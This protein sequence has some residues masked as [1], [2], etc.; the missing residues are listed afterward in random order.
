MQLAP[1]I[2][3]IIHFILFR[4]SSSSS[5]ELLGN[6]PVGR[7]CS[8]QVGSRDYT[9]FVQGVSVR[10]GSLQAVQ[11]RCASEFH[12]FVEQLLTRWNN[13]DLIRAFRS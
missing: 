7:D 6:L 2:Q 13:P 10:K 9:C 12:L 1:A 4:V 5:K 11:V 3:T 8:T